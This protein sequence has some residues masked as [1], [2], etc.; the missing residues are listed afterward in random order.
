MRFLVSL[1]LVFILVFIFWP[2]YH[3]YRIDNALGRAEP[4]ALAPL[5]DLEAIR[6]NTKQRLEWALGLKNVMTG[7]NPMGWFQQGLQR[8]GEV[9]LEETINLEWVQSQLRDAA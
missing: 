4:A 6:D 5:T 8:A 3:L 2:Y 1:L 9:A 7:G